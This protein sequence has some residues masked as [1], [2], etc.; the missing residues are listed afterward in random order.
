MFNSISNAFS[1]AK[2]AFGDQ[3]FLCNYFLLA[4]RTRLGSLVD[5]ST[6]SIS[7]SAS[8]PSGMTLLLPVN[9]SQGNKSSFLF[10]GSSSVTVFV[11]STM[12]WQDDTD[13]VQDYSCLTPTFP[14]LFSFLVAS[15][16]SIGLRHTRQSV[17]FPS[18]IH[19]LRQGRWTQRLSSSCCVIKLPF[20]IHYSL[21]CK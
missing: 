3:Y 14:P 15:P 5:A 8:L 11:R 16:S 19:E 17:R 9:L 12:Y 4:P 2:I 13:W 18:R 6:L 10:A 20:R 21:R 7:P 1:N